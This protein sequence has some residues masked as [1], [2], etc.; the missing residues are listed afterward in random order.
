[1]KKIRDVA[2]RKRWANSIQTQVCFLCGKGFG[3]YGHHREIMHIL[4]GAFRSDIEENLCLGG[5]R[6]H[7]STHGITVVIDGVKTPKYTITDVLRGKRKFD[8]KNF[9]IK[10]LEELKGETLPEIDDV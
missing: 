8:S 2:R 6:C 10:V 7:S 4:G 9:S 3:A 1:M 5:A